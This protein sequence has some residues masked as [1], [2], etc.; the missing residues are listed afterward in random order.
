MSK[1]FFPTSRLYQKTSHQSWSPSSLLFRTLVPVLRWA[2]GA[3]FRL[4]RGEILPRL[5][6]AT[7]A[8][9]GPVPPRSQQREII[10]VI[11]IPAVAQPSTPVLLPKNQ[12][13]HV[14]VA[15]ASALSST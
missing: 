12:D 15:G 9:L 6:A 4:L 7:Y 5:I 11:I 3:I 2:F 8:L 13:S 1:L 10:I 14:I